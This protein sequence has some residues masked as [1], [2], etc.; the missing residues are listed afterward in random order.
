MDIQEI[1]L[2]L[3]K[4]KPTLIEAFVTFYGESYRDRIESVINSITF[5]YVSKN[6]NYY[7]VVPKEIINSESIT[8]YLNIRNKEY[9]YQIK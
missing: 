6:N 8:L 2:K 1:N 9:K 3:N 7:L 4:L 5:V